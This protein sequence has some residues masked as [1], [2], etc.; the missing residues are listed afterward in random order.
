[1]NYPKVLIM[2]KAQYDKLNFLQEYKERMREELKSIEEQI[3]HYEQ[4]YLEETQTSGIYIYIIHFSLGNIVRGWENMGQ[5][6]ISIGKSRRCRIKECDRIFSN[7]SITSPTNI[8]SNSGYQL[9]SDKKEGFEALCLPA[10]RLKV[11]EGT[12]STG[13]GLNMLVCGKKQG[14]GKK[15]RGK[16]G[17]LKEIKMEFSEGNREGDMINGIHGGKRGS[18]Y[19]LIDES[20]TSFQSSY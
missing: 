4:K 8:N 2:E 11:E 20:S 7:S 6:V 1:M 18:S 19:N 15:K 5:K 3:Y 16:K 9:R 17:G 10:K 13:E 12:D 14:K